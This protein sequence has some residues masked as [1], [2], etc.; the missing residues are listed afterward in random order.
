V[1]AMRFEIVE[2]TPEMAA[3]FLLKSEGNRKLR[4]SHAA[5]L[6]RAIVDGKYQLTHQAAAVTKRGKLI[7]GQ[8]RMRAIMLANKP[9]QLVIAFDVPDDTFAVLDSGLIRNMAD[10]LRADKFQTMVCTQLFRLM[11]RQGAAQ[12]YEIETM[13]ECLQ[14]AL[15]KYAAVPK[16]GFMKGLKGPHTAAIVLRMADAMDRQ[17]Q[18]GVLRVQWLV[19]KLNRKDMTGAPPII[20]AFFRQICEGVA[21]FDIGVAPQT[22]QFCRAWTAFDPEKE[23]VVRLQINDHHA[24]LKEAREVFRRI[25]QSVFE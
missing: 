14:G 16:H 2:V 18:D 12:E 1:T 8:H 25:T 23:A 5:K 24:D 22:D 11:I 19:E 6:S 21:N 9:V 10:R 20:Q 17:D 15:D 3:K 7:D 4:E 13:L